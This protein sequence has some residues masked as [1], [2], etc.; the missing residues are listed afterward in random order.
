MRSISSAASPF[1]TTDEDML[2]IHRPWGTQSRLSGER[3][4]DSLK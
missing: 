2:D 1:A 3:S 4:R